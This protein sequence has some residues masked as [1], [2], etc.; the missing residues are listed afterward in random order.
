MESKWIAI[1][2]SV[3]CV[4]MYSAIAVGAYTEN[5]SKAAIKVACYEAQAKSTI[6]L[7]CSELK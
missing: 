5:K 7:K 2:G 1:L 4:S 3:F 6:D